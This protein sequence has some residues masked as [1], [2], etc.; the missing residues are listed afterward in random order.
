MALPVAPVGPRTNATYCGTDDGD[1]DDGVDGIGV[2]LVLRKETNP[3][4]EV[5]DGAST[6]AERAMERSA[7]GIWNPRG[8][9]AC[10]KGEAGRVSHRCTGLEEEAKGCGNAAIVE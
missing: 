4:I 3:P 7:R 2:V 9:F 10:A 8:E 6:R 5:F 1:G